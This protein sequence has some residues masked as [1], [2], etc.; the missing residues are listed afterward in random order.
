MID[1]ERLRLLIDTADSMGLQPRQI[2]GTGLVALHVHG[3]ER[4]IFHKS[5]NPN[6]A[7][8]TFLT[9][10]K[11]A[12]RIVF[13]EHEL[14]NIPYCVPKTEDE[15]IAFLQT[16]GR[17][18]VKPITGQHSSNIHLVS[19]IDELKKIDT[20]RGIFEKFVEGQETRLLVVAG[21]VKAV[22]LKV[23]DSEIND[24]SKVRRISLEKQQWNQS[25]VIMAQ[26]AAEAFGLVFT[27]VDFLVTRDDEPFLLEINA[28]P[29][30]ERFNKPT[31]GP[32]V[33]AMRFYLEQ[34]TRQL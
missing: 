34:F 6:S 20:A 27:A 14:P 3:K 5:S 4:Y 25:L 7:A 19:S 31:E 33:D 9:K 15:A 24:P 22:H 26:K 16:H 13:G 29:G 21:E 11:R 17:V 2:N 23:Y 30:I 10:N 28:A 1:P 8:A 12:A 18:I 32:P